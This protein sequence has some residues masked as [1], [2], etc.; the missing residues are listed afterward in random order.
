MPIVVAQPLAVA[1]HDDGGRWA[2]NRNG[3]NNNYVNGTGLTSELCHFCRNIF[4]QSFLPFPVLEVVSVLDQFIVTYGFLL[5][6][7]T[8]RLAGD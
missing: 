7:P 4:G 5:A 6:L 1:V 2:H 8:G 3:V